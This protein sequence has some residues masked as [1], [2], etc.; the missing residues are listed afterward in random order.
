MGFRRNPAPTAE[1]PAPLLPIPVGVTETRIQHAAWVARC[2]GRGKSAPLRPADVTALASVL[3]VRAF[4]PASV[5]F[6]GG[7]Q[8]TGVWIV[9]EGQIELSVGSRGRRVVVQLLRPGD[10]DGD[11]QLLLEMPLPYTGR[12]LSCVTCLFLAREDFEQLLATHPAIARR[13][14]SSVAQRL[15]ASQVRVLELLGG[16]LAVQASRLLAA[17]S[18]G[19]RVELPQRTLAAM[20]GVQRPSLNK[21]LKDL[22]R[23]GLIRISYGAIEIRDT[24]RLASRA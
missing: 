2:V 3:A 21:V 18:V 4:P 20:L 14:L 13:W 11:I 23:D 22:E 10:V 16:S 8:T 19:G 7:D 12:A 24:T 17:E 6:A 5:L 9:R 15:A 1:R